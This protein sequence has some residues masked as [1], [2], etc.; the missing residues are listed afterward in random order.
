VCEDGHDKVIY[1]ADF[2]GGLSE[3]SCPICEK[4]KSLSIEK[5]RLSA[6]KV[7]RIKSVVREI[8][9]AKDELR[10]IESEVEDIIE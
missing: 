2:F 1:D 8:R 5:A 7:N 10:D 6:E 9:C 3:R 4:L